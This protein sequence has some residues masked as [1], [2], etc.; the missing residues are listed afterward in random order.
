VVFDDGRADRIRDVVERLGD[1]AD[2]RELT[3]LLS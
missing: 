1:L 2:V 3:S